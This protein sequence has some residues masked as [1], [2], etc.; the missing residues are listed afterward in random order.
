MINTISSI[1]QHYGVGLDVI[2]SDVEADN[3]I[4]ESR[5]VVN[6]RADNIIKTNLIDH[7]ASSLQSEEQKYSKLQTMATG[8][9][10]K[11]NVCSDKNAPLSK[12]NYMHNSFRQKFD[13][14][15]KKLSEILEEDPVRLIE[16][17]ARMGSWVLVSTIRF[18]QF[19]KK[20][21]ARL[22]QLRA[23]NAI[24][25]QFRLIFDMQAF[26]QSDIPD[27]FLFENAISFH[28]TEQNSE[29]FEG[30]D[31]IWSAVLDER[32]LIKLNDKID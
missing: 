6:I 5:R 1:A 29:E 15:D 17:C 18:P 12:L 20:V 31:D 27:S 7:T 32:V 9:L 22:A 16:R 10:K 13:N 30:F 4:H 24:D 26:S 11:G 28:M 3:L 23:E 19:Q 21:S 2:R 25:D 14:P 8:Y